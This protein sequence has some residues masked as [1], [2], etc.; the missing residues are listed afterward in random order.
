MKMTMV[1]DLEEVAEKPMRRQLQKMAQV[2]RADSDGA[3]S[4]ALVIL[5]IAEAKELKPGQPVLLKAAD[6]NDETP[7]KLGR[8]DE[9]TRVAL[10]QVEGL[11]QFADGQRRSPVGAFLTAT[12]AAKTKNVLVIPVTALLTAADGTFVYV[13]NGKHFTRTKIKTGTVSDG[14]VEVE[15]GVYPGDEVVARGVDNL[16]LIELSALKGGKPCCAVPKKQ[17]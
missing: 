9:S 11:L 12:F 17:A 10:G 1:L 5:T 13:S 16:W 8:L 2:F 15:E 7:G 14:Y 6:S 3:K 4:E